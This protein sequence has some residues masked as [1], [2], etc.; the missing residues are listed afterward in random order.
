MGHMNVMWYVGK[1]DE[2]TWQLFGS[3]GLSPTRLRNERIGLAAV[4]QRLE[5]KR[6]LFAGDLL[7]IRSSIDEVR[8]KSLVLIHEMI[9]QETEEM[10]ART[11]ITG[12]CMDLATRKARPLPIDI[13]ERMTSGGMR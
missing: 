13:R 10:A 7:T 4:E 9:N 8:E 1:F 6:E 12:V 3:F 11:I 2:A 5:Y